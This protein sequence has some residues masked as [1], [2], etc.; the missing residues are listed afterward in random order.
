MLSKSEI[1]EKIKS[2]E[3]K[4]VAIQAIW[5]GDTTGWMLDLQA[6]YKNKT[7]RIA[8][9]R[10]GGDMKL[11]NGTVPPWSEVELAKSIGSISVSSS[12][13]KEK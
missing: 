8:T 3:K 6:V 7:M 2:L 12:T 5:D 10:D 13:N 1:I 9:L 11:F 4:P